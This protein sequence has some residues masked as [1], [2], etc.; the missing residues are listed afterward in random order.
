MKFAILDY[1][2]EKNISILNIQDSFLTK[3]VIQ[4]NYALFFYDHKLIMIGSFSEA[5]K[6]LNE[7]LLSQTITTLEFN[8]KI[9]KYEINKNA[10]GLLSSDRRLYIHGKNIGK[11]RNLG[12]GPEV[13]AT[14]KLTQIQFDQEAVLDF[15]LSE[16]HGCA[17]TQNGSLWFWGRGYSGETG[18]NG[19]ST[20]DFPK[21][22][23]NFVT[24]DIKKVFCNKYASLLLSDHDAQLL[25]RVGGASSVAN[26]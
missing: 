22:I 26:S 6:P 17:L 14:A 2:H 25:G 1:Y 23:E 9:R 12:L 19:F 16:K 21:K 18:Q 7:I 3:F 15:S 8:F 5:K 13:T 10:F 24:S 4:D 11:N 20:L